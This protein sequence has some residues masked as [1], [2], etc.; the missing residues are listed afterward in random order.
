MNLN[1]K[2]NNMKVND[3]VEIIG[4]IVCLGLIFGLFYIAIHIGC[5]C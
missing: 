4:S 3:I 2:V 5:P 1:T